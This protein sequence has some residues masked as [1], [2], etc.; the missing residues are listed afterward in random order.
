M[1]AWVSP[2]FAIY[3]EAMWAAMKGGDADRGEGSLDQRQTM[4]FIGG[5][6]HLAF[7]R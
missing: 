6:F 1:E 4:F 3:G 2:R 7:G 5:K